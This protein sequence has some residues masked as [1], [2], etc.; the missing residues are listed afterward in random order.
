MQP[1]AQNNNTVQRT[2]SVN[3]TT[4]GQSIVPSVTDT[5]LPQVPQQLQSPQESELP[6]IQEHKPPLWPFVLFLVLL[7]GAV[8]FGYIFAAR[9]MPQEESIPT[10][11]VIPP[12]PS[13]TPRSEPV[14]STSDAILDVERD[15]DDLDLSGMDAELPQLS[16]ELQNL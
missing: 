6:I 15:L 14:V 2:A 12:F 4:S 16:Q 1:E 5:P 11:I 13:L 9:K 3:A 10:P 7:V 8:V